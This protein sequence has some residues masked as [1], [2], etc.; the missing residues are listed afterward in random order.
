MFPDAAF[1]ELFSLEDLNASIF[2]VSKNFKLLF[3]SSMS[4]SFW[5]IFIFKVSIA[6]LLP[7]F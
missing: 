3:K 6:M 2:W 5:L 4:L 7:I 1:E